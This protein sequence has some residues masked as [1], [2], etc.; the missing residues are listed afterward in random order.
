[1]RR[2]QT[3]RIKDKIGIK[4]NGESNPGA[5]DIS[6]SESTLTALTTTDADSVGGGRSTA[7]SNKPRQSRRT[8]KKSTR[9]REI[10]DYGWDWDENA[11]WDEDIYDADEISDSR[12]KK[13]RKAGS[14]YDSSRLSSVLSE[15]GRVPEF[16]INHPE[17]ERV[18]D[19]HEMG[20][21]HLD[22]F[23]SASGSGSST[24]TLA[25]TNVP[26]RVEGPVMPMFGHDMLFDDPLPMLGNDPDLR[27]QSVSS[28][29]GV[30]DVGE[31]G[32]M[33]AFIAWQGLDGEEKD[34]MSGLGMGVDVDGIRSDVGYGTC[35]G[36]L[37]G[38]L[39]MGL[40]MNAD[41]DMGIGLD[42]ALSYNITAHMRD[43]TTHDDTNIDP[44]LRSRADSRATTSSSVSTGSTASTSTTCTKRELSM[45]EITLAI[46]NVA[47]A[48]FLPALP[49]NSLGVRS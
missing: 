7:G 24:D 9:A 39:D 43:S 1:L 44:V 41:M 11:D 35:M 40:G 27:M 6:P 34:K 25:A 29:I 36:G 10:E 33:G 15:Q 8:R 14:V 21:V 20:T 28:V 2:S 19:A 48:G 5:R 37:M 46:Q 3:P 30:G 4:F 32:D 23:V 17:P 22:M 38:D 42:T 26:E 31:V 13:R 16:T 45:A 18:H 47:K 49:V 12:P